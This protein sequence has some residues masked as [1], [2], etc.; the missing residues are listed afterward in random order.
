MVFNLC[1]SAVHLLLSTFA[2]SNS[3][4]KRLNGSEIAC[5]YFVF[6]EEMCLCSVLA[7]DFIRLVVHHSSDLETSALLTKFTA[8][9]KGLV[10]LA[11]EFESFEVSVLA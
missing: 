10:S 4:R 6:S 8:R 7:E 2:F 3:E 9:E 1:C 11:T 5:I